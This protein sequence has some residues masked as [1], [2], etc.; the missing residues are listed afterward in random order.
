MSRQHLFLFVKS[1]NNIDSSCINSFNLL[2][3]T[4][5]EACHL[6]NVFEVHISFGAIGKNEEI[7]FL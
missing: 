6:I 4:K 7:V 1:Q 5:N 3:I 2:F